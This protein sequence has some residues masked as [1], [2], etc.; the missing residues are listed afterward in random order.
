MI[1]QLRWVEVPSG[2][3]CLLVQLSDEIPELPVNGSEAL[4][5]MR[6]HTL[7]GSLVVVGLLL[8]SLGPAWWGNVPTA[9]G[10]EK[11]ELTGLAGPV[12]QLYTPASG[13]FLARTQGSLYRSDDGGASWVPVSLP[14]PP[15][16]PARIR[17]EVDPTNHD[18]L[19]ASGA[20]G[21]YR[22]PDGGASWGL[23]LP[24]DDRTVA[25]VA[26]SSADPRLVYVG[27]TSYSHFW[28]L[29]SRDAGATWEPLEEVFNSLCAWGVRI[30][31]P[32]S[33][34]PDRLFR[35]AS[36]YAG[37]DFWD[38]L[39][40]S[41][42]QGVTWTTRFGSNQAA[43]PEFAFPD[44]LVGGRG[45]VPGHF[46]LAAQRDFREGGS[47]LFRSDDDAASWAEV[48]AFRGGG[49]Y[50]EPDAPNVRIGGLAYDPDQP[51]RVYVALNRT[52]GSASDQTWL[53]S[54]ALVSAD[55]GASWSDLAEQD[56]GRV[57]DL[58][59]GIDGQN[60]Y[61]ATDRGLRRLRLI[62]PP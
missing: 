19:Y 9:R 1:D 36:C 10:Q 5:S 30:L 45:A 42:D 41:R 22:S 23:L 4:D 60:L 58:A 20:E 46:Y 11:W 38:E 17:V 37:R 40:E 51:D 29:R 25:A 47:S 34:D 56:L 14:P 2:P 12:E 59:L 18:V 27:L 43:E 49:S 39:A 7:R 33:T 44:D 21:L 62:P 48:L 54:L 6:F 24:T 35:T 55:G 16:D 32:H 13:A 28:F 57:A 31:E 50:R 53:G 3:R 15:A 52:L 61:A 8:A 26:V